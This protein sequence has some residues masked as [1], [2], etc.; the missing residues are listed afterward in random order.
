MTLRSNRGTWDVGPRLTRPMTEDEYRRLAVE[1]IMAAVEDLS[2]SDRD[3]AEDALAFINSGS[4]VI[5]AETL[6]LDAADLRQGLRGRTTKG[7][8]RT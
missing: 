5:W 1:V 6:D 4:F 7:G 3:K 8:N 2:S